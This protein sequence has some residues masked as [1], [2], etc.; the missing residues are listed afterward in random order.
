MLM[1][2]GI[3]LIGGRGAGRCR[4][5]VAECLAAGTAE[6]LCDYLAGWL[7]NLITGFGELAGSLTG[8]W[9]AWLLEE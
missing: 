9:V 3:P 4:P 8:L 5:G 1:V 7:T 2:F 6:W